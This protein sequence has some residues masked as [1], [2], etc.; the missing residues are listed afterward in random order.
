M[1]VEIK[2]LA[3]AIA[4]IELG[5]STF[6]KL[7]PTVLAGIEYFKKENITDEDVAAMKAQDQAAADNQ[8]RAIDKAKARET[9]K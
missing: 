3:S 8:Q 5:I 7:T 6:E 4:A 2:D 1:N 9:E